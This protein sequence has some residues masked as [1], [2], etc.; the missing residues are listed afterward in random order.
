MSRK[1][2]DDKTLRAKTLH[3]HGDGTHA[4]LMVSKGHAGVSICGRRD[5]FCRRVGRR[6][7]YTRLKTGLNPPEVYNDDYGTKVRFPKHGYYNLEDHNELE[8]L[9]N[10]VYASTSDSKLLSEFSR[11]LGYLK[12][13]KF[14]AP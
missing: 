11:A 10:W 9:Y 3:V 13:K 12:E 6:I 8:E 5:N 2:A 1:L 4:T 14:I 7:A